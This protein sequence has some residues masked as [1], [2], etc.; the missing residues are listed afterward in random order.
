MKDSGN[1]DQKANL[2]ELK[3]QIMRQDVTG[4]KE[5]VSEFQEIPTYFNN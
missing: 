4:E 3:Q 5:G 1:K 2:S